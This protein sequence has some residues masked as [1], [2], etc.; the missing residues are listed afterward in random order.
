MDLARRP[1]NGPAL[2]AIGTQSVPQPAPD[3]NL[4]SAS[5]TLDLTSTP[6]LGCG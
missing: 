6:D 2:I 4:K 1:A 3:Q 5:K